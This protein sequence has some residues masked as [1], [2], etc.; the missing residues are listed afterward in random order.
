M[1]GEFEW[2]GYAAQALSG[3]SEALQAAG[4]DCTVPQRN[5]HNVDTDIEHDGRL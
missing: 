3:V 5:D 4:V 1:S 2:G